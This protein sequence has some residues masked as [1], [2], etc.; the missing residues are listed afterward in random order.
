MNKNQVII[1]AYVWSP[2][3]MMVINVTTTINYKVIRFTYERLV[4]QFSAGIVARIS[5]NFKHRNLSIRYRSKIRKMVIYSNNHFLDRAWPTLRQILLSYGKH[6]MCTAIQ[7]IG[8]YMIGT[9]LL[10]VLTETS[11]L[12]EAATGG[13]LKKLFLKVLL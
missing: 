12:T 10:T 2:W 7:S 9:L 11:V 3:Y 8:F 4:A 5:Q 6:E 13:V 1:K